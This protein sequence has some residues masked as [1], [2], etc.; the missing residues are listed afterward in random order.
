VEFTEVTNVE[1]PDFDLAM[2]I[3]AEAF[4]ANERQPINVVKERVKNGLNQ[5]YVGRIGNDIVFMALLWP[6]KNTDFIL[7]DYMAT[8]SAHRGK[9][10]GSLFLQARHRDL[11]ENKKYFIMEVE[12]PEFGDNKE[13]RE[14]RLAFYK[15]NGAKEL[16]GVNYILPALQGHK[17]TEMI[18][19]ILPNYDQGK[20]PANIVKNLITQIYKELYNREANGTVL[21]D[22]RFDNNA[23]IE[24]T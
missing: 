10:I 23:S 11:E 2:D 13:E 14:R 22:W 12:D 9:N 7:L 20:I 17:A 19:M 8:N 5:I 1:N 15:K 6:L 4:P 18:L 3:Y 24:L 16:K 21:N